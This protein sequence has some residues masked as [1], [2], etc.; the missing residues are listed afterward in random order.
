MNKDQTLYYWSIRNNLNHEVG[1][2]D[3]E[4]A[5]NPAE[6][7]VVYASQC[8]SLTSKRLYDI[9]YSAIECKLNN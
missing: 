8:Y 4:K 3:F 6:A 9:G 1:Y 7:L 5:A 2:V